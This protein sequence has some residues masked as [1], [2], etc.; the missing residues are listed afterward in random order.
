LFATRLTRITR[1]LKYRSID[2]A[3]DE[4]S[5]AVPDWAGG[6]RIG[7]SVKTFNYQWLRRVLRGQ[8]VVLIISDGWDRGDPELLARET[9]RLQRSCHRLIWLNPLLGSPTYQ[10]LTQGMKAALPYIDDFLPVHNLNSLESL[11]QHLSSLRPDRALGHAYRPPMAPEPEP[12][13]AVAADRP[14][15]RLKLPTFQ[16]PEWGKRR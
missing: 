4:V 6:T 15:D 13:P 1:N 3:I 12:E 8:A 2:Q 5:K 10:P 7:D 11:A 14:I 9:S 16:H